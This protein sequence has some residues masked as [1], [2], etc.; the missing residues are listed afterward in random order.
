VNKEEIFKR[1]ERILATVKII[2]M[3]PEVTASAPVDAPVTPA[4]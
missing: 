2:P 1:L 3:T 4:Q